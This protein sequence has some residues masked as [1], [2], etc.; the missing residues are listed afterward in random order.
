MCVNSVHVGS[1]FPITQIICI[2]NVRS[3]PL[4]VTVLLPL[5]KYTLVN[6]ATLVT[7]KGFSRPR[8]L[9]LGVVK[10]QTV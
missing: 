1:V 10:S 3:L 7:T 4:I 9:I 2:S 5:E 8:H 6:V